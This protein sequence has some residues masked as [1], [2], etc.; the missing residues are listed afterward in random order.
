MSTSEEIIE[1]YRSLRAAADEVACQIGVTGEI[2]SKNPLIDNL[3]NELWVSDKI[4]N[5]KPGVDE[6]I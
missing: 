1:G 4:L 6:K 2:N 5:M 3:M